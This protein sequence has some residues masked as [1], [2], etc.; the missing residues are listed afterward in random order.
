M[1]DIERRYHETWLGMAQPIEGLVVSVPV[2][3]D[4]QCMLRL[5]LSEQHK[6]V[7]LTGEQ[8]PRVEDVP[9]FLREVLGYPDGSFVTELPEALR[10]DI[11]E[12]QQTLVPTRGLLRRGPPP[13]RPEGLPDDSTP[14]S[15]AAEPFVLCPR[16]INVV[17]SS[18]L[19]CVSYGTLNNDP[20]NSNL[21]A[22]AGIDAVIVDSVLRVSTSLV[23]P[24]TGGHS[25]GTP[26]M[27]P[28]TTSRARSTG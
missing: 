21:Q 14:T 12:G 10:L 3:V 4:A 20:R 17:Q 6:L 7:A 1:N 11:V 2:L 15:R 9:R 8:S 25:N 22:Q 5:P 27:P 18:E 13:A 23:G 28:A 26:A 24:K 19:V 16:L